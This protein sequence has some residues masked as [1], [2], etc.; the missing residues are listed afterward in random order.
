VDDSK[1]ALEKEQL[2]LENSM[3]EPGF[4]LNKEK[5]Q[6]TIRR[7]QELK[8]E[9]AGNGKYDAGD[10]VMTIFSGAGGDDAEDFSAML[11]N[12][13][14]KFCNKHNFGMTVLHENENDHGG[15]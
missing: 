1:I 4:W 10:A 13:Y 12:M 11:L 8:N 3:L 6:A 14:M 15:F 7:I 5:A 2:D 9:I